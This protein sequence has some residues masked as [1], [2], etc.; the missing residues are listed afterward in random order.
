MAKRKFYALARYRDKTDG[1]LKVG[2]LPREGFTVENNLGFNLS[3]Y[4]ATDET[5]STN[6][7]EVKTWFVVDEDCGLSV[8]QGNTKNNA[9]ANALER[10]VKIDKEQ[11]RKSIDSAREKY[12]PVPGHG[13][14]YL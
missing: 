10:L 12:G 4:R 5:A 7:K 9:I 14:M 13:V 6:Y 3:V 11:Y 8:G 1:N 2:Y